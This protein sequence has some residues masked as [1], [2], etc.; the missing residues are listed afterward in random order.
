MI[1]ILNQTLI[2]DIIQDIYIINIYEREDNIDEFIVDYFGLLT[3]DKF[4]NS[5]FIELC[6]SDLYK[7]K[8]FYKDLEK[9]NLEISIKNVKEHI[10]NIDKCFMKYAPRVSN[11]MSKKVFGEEWIELMKVKGVNSEFIVKNF[12]SISSNMD[13]ASRFAGGD[14]CIFK[15]ITNRI[16]IY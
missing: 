9:E 12:Q 3:N 13:I 14:C 6:K 5:N 4:N 7:Y 2:K 8:K 11:A 15:I 10:T 1:H 16:T